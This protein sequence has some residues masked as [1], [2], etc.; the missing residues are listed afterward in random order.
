MSEESAQFPLLALPDPCLLAVLQC[1][2]ADDYCSLFSA[3]RAHSRLHHA[4]VAALHSIDI[5]VRDQQQA[6]SVL[7]YLHRHGSHVNSL[8]LWSP[9]GIGSRLL[10]FQLPPSLQLNSLQLVGWTLQLQPGNGFQGVMGS[11]AGAPPLKQLRLRDCTLLDGPEALEAALLQLPALEHLSLGNLED[12]V[13]QSRPWLPKPVCFPTGVL[14]QLPKLIH[15]E[16][17][18]MGEGNLDVTASMLS[19]ACHLTRLALQGAVLEPGALGGKAK[20]QHLELI[21]SD[22]EPEAAAGVAALLSQLQHQTQLTYLQLYSWH[23]DHELSGHPPIAAYA[24]LTASSKLQHLDISGCNLPAGV[25]QHIFPAGRQL[26]HLTLLDISEVTQLPDG[27]ATAPEGSRLVSC[28]PSL[29]AFNMCSLQYSPQQLTQLQG[30]SGLH[31]LRLVTGTWQ[32]SPGDASADTGDTLQA[33]AQLTGLRE[34]Q[35]YV[36]D[37]PTQLL[38]TQL[39]QLQQLPHLTA[40]EYDTHEGPRTHFKQAVSCT[41]W[42]GA[43]CLIVRAW[44]HVACAGTCHRGSQCAASQL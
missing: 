12:A 8:Q 4:A 30:L 41:V 32:I 35:L 2:A 16:L 1:F 34:L 5:D 18:A 13:L 3:A 20:L 17:A 11:A 36:C 7:V 10:L 44:P 26:P 43:R 39:Q 25:W 29:Q 23:A 28:C 14:K 27:A 15:L 40:L 9:A 22:W 21:D 42:G 31:T 6:D 38:V 33:V 24:G 19:D 37:E